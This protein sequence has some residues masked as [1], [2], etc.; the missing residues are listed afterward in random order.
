VLEV[1]IPGGVSGGGSATIDFDPNHYSSGIILRPPS[2]S[3]SDLLSAD[4]SGPTIPFARP[5]HRKDGLQDN[6]AISKPVYQRPKHER[7]FCKHCDNHPDGFRGEHELKRHQDREHGL[8]DHPQ[9]PVPTA[10]LPQTNPNADS[11]M[12]IPV[13]ALSSRFS[14]SDFLPSPSFSRFHP[15]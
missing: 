3:G 2:P 14:T 1:Q 10:Q 13:T 8:F 6:F 11:E 7:V 4:A 5:L 12:D 15:E 9:H